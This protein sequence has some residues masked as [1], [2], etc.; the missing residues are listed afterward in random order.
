[1]MI[2]TEPGLKDLGSLREEC[3]AGGLGV[4]GVAQ[5]KGS[6]LHSAGS[7]GTERSIF[8]SPGSRIVSRDSDAERRPIAKPRE[9]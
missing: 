5:R 7:Q 4:C 8:A 9:Q 6:Q 3:G 2:K 1:M